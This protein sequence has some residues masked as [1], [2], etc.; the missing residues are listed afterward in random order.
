[1]TSWC[2][3]SSYI[4]AVLSATTYDINIEGIEFELKYNNSEWSVS[5]KDFSKK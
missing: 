4:D 2:P 1:M 3:M 5:H